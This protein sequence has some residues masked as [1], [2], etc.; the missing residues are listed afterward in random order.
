VRNRHGRS[1]KVSVR[2]SAQCPRRA[3]ISAGVKTGWESQLG[4]IGFVEMELTL[5][6]RM[7]KEE[8]NQSL[9]HHPRLIHSIYEWTDVRIDDE[10]VV[11][12]FF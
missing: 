1:S 9:V 3:G 4:E 12:P 5:K 2:S 6:A 8:S 11:S 7:E 10:K